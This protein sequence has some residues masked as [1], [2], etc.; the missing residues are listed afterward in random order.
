MDVKGTWFDLNYIRDHHGNSISEREGATKRHLK[1]R[2]HQLS[3]N[4][5][6]EL[7]LVQ[8]T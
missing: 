8:K 2:S 4:Q 3:N 7:K 5:L 1:R 6:N